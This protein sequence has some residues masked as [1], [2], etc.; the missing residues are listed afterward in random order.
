MAHFIF[1]N[2]CNRG[3]V[4]SPKHRRDVCVHLAGAEGRS[5]EAF[6]AVRGEKRVHKSNVYRCCCCL[7]HNDPSYW[8]RI[9]WAVFYVAQ[10]G[11]TTMR[12]DD[13]W[14]DLYIYMVWQC[15]LLWCYSPQH[16]PTR[17]CAIHAFYF[18][19]NSWCTLWYK[20]IIYKKNVVQFSC[21]IL[22]LPWFGFIINAINILRKKNVN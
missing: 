22:F 21:N 19:Q 7:L 13:K 8:G 18:L 20:F 1:F 14:L 9:P 12:P 6:V 5:E 2:L 11:A 3:I 10:W 16:K 17:H 15:C 4:A